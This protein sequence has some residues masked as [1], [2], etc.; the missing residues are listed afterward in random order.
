MLSRSCAD[1]KHVILLFSLCLRRSLFLSLQSGVCILFL[2][3]SI[4]PPRPRYRKYENCEGTLRLHTWPCFC[5]N[6]FFFIPVTIHENTVNDLNQRDKGLGGAARAKETSDTE[7]KVKNANLGIGTP[8]QRD[9]L[10]KHIT[11]GTVSLVSKLLAL[12]GW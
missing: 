8:S 9:E 1:I 4:L 11:L 5:V 2:F 10:T 6:C 12:E 7:T 3:L